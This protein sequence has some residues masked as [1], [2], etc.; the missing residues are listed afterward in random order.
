MFIEV[1]LFMLLFVEQ[2]ATFTLELYLFLAVFD[3]KV[4]SSIF[5]SMI[6]KSGCCNFLLIL[7]K[8]LI[9]LAYGLQ[10]TLLSELF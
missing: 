8:S 4:V 7:I 6:T 10:K 9:P 3:S 2:I 5:G 1:F